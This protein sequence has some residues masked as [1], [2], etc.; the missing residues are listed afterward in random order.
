M[1]LLFLLPTYLQAQISGPIHNVTIRIDTSVYD[2]S[3]DAI[4]INGEK[5]LAFQFNDAQPTIQVRVYA[6]RKLE[7]LALQPSGYFRVFDSLIWMPDG[8]YQFRVRFEEIVEARFPTFTFK[9]QQE[10]NF[11]L[12][13]VPL[14]PYQHTLL[15]LKPTNTELYIGEEKVFDLLCSD[16][17]NLQIDNQWVELDGLEYRVSIQNGEPKLHIVPKELGRLTLEL[18]MKTRQPS[19]GSD[20]K[21][22]Y[23]LPLIVQDFIVKASRL[24]FLDVNIKNVIHSTE[25]RKKG[26]EVQIVD[27]IQ[28]QINKTY[29]IENQSDHGG[30]LVAELITR[31]RLSNNRVLC[32][33]RTHD[34]H[35]VAD[36][37]LYIKDGDI[38]KFITNFDIIHETEIREIS[39]LNNQGRWVASRTVYPGQTVDL[40]MEGEGLSNTTLAFEGAQL[41]QYDS[42][43]GNDKI[44]YYRLKIPMDI[45]NREIRIVSFGK[46]VGPSLNV[47]EHA[48]PA[49]LSF[50][51][52][53][54]GAGSKSM[55][56]YGRQVQYDHVVNDVLLE[57]DTDAI[58]K[59]SNMH[60]VQ[61]LNVKV[62][63]R[64]S[65]NQLVDMREIDNVVVCPGVTSPRYGFYNQTNCVS[66]ILALNQFLSRKTYDLEEWD[67]IIVTVAHNKDKY[68]GLGQSERLEIVQRRNLI[69]DIDV[70]FPA[71]LLTKRQSRDRFDNM[72]GI[73]MAMI[74]QFTFYHPERIAVERPYKIG[75][76]FIA[77]NAFNF[78]ENNTNRDIGLV[79][80]GSL[81]PRTKKRL[82]FPLYLGGGYLLSSSDW[83]YM[84]GPGIRVSL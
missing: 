33:L 55:P 14:F 45:K 6:N 66:N 49:P 41:V 15:S 43:I 63:L 16:P 75:A 74:A 84:L 47:V 68:G 24:A 13:T 12:F 35:S 18:L 76:G 83:F 1:L 54:F 56:K 27:H 7:G 53:D 10:G 36:G 78:S 58:D 38:P 39:I 60:G 11:G 26:V 8:Y 17:T 40:K 19:I 29:R 22:T 82:S 48:R 81:Y 51:N 25:S 3:R 70:S 32:W 57:F 4:N 23:D 67:K 72:G 28:L 21:L 20:R 42:L 37:Y 64:T 52:L 9:V 61:H 50:V 77:L 44:G 5:H 80:L 73:S 46:P 2:F 79:F 62:E 59:V 65:R 30:Y 71:G 34:Y 69:F 31:S